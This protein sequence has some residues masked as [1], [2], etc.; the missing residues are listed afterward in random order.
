MAHSEPA[1]SDASELAGL[2][3]VWPPFR[4][5]Q[6]YAGLEFHTQKIMEFSVIGETPK[7]ILDY[8]SGVFEDH[9]DFLMG[10]TDFEPLCVWGRYKHQMILN[11]VIYASK[12]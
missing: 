8:V 7:K 1:A 4:V 6:P 3:A 11:V 2:R 10:F 9:R 5:H 12:K